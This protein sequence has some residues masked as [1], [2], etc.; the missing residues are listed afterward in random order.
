MRKRDKAWQGLLTTVN[1]V[2]SLVLEVVRL[3]DR[4]TS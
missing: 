3:I 4:L 1:T 2:V